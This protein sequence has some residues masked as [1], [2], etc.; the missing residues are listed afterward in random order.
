M[1]MEDPLPLPCKLGATPL[2]HQYISQY[3]QSNRRPVARMC[4]LLQSSLI[5]THYNIFNIFKFY[6]DTI[7]DTTTT[8]Q[9]A[10]S[11]SE[12]CFKRWIKAI[13]NQKVH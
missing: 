9:V 3:N 5:L 4:L 11:L 7:H 2:L 10:V 8:D 13:S 1:V 6:R 12:S